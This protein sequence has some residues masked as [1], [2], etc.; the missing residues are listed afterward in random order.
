MRITEKLKEGLG[1]SETKE[2]ENKFYDLKMRNKRR[3]EDETKGNKRD[4]VKRFKKREVKRLENE[5]EDE[6]KKTL[7]D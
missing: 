2:E 6:R 5:T 3:L 7:E 1:D 4:D